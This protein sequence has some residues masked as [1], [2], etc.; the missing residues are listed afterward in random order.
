MTVAQR[1]L[2]VQ[3]VI[4][5]GWSSARA[6]AN[7]GVSEHLIDVWVAEF[8]RHGMRSLRRTPGKTLP[9]EIV[10]L[11]ISRPLRGIASRVASGLRRLL[12]RERLPEPLPLQRFYD[13]R[14][15]RD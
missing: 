6:S 5:D 12:V 1:A 15:G 14:R 7:F 10:H 8:R 9:A 11:T 3:R 13:D 2:I 4:V